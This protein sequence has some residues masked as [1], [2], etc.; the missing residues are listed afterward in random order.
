MRSTFNDAI[1]QVTPDTLNSSNARAVDRVSP[2]SLIPAS[3]SITYF[4][5][6]GPPHTLEIM[7]PMPYTHVEAYLWKLSKGG[8]LIPF[9]QMYKMASHCTE[10]PLIGV[11][12]PAQQCVAFDICLDIAKKAG[13]CWVPVDYPAGSKRGCIILPLCERDNGHPLRMKGRAWGRCGIS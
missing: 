7:G 3:S 13:V 11:W 9:T 12:D 1:L 4:T 5:C 6:F 8:H 2:Q 10:E